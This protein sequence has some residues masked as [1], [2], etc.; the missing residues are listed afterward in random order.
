MMQ[1]GIAVALGAIPVVFAASYPPVCGAHQHQEFGRASSC[2]HAPIPRGWISH[3]GSGLVD[4]PVARWP[5]PRYLGVACC[6]GPAPGRPWTVGCPSGSRF[7]VVPTAGRTATQS[8]A[9]P[10]A[11]TTGGDIGAAQTDEQSTAP[12]RRHAAATD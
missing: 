1:I 7:D 2:R 11:A 4:A 6:S 9:V 3:T 12:R 5:G 10:G 8:C